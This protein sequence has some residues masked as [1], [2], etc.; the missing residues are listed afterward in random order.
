MQKWLPA[1]LDY[2]PR[3]IEFQMRQTETPGCVVAIAAKGDMVLEQAFGVADLGSGTALTALHRFRVASHSKSFT[4]A[5]IM[6]LREAGRLE[7]DDPAGRFVDGL[8]PTVAEVTLA[9]L[10]S[11]SAGL[12]RDGT[13][14]GQWQDR[15]PFLSEDELRAALAEAPTLPP[16]SRF[17]YSNH[18][19]GL[20]GLIIEAIT[21][22]SYCDWIRREVVAAAGLKETEPDMPIAADAPMARGHGAKLPLGRRLVIPGDNPTHALAAATGFVSTAADLAR[23]FSQLDPEAKQSMLSVASRREMIRRQWRDAYSSVERHYGLGIMCS[24]TGDLEWFGHGG[25]FQGFISRTVVVP[26]HGLA[27]SIVT[28]TVERLAEQWSDGALH[29]ISAFARRGAPEKRLRNWSGRWW[30]VWNALDLVPV[31]DRV[32]ILT[33]ALPNPLTDASEVEVTGADAGQ[34]ALAPGL[35]N[36]GEPVRRSRGA[37][38]AVDEVWLGGTRLLPET[39]MAAELKARYGK[40]ATA[41]PRR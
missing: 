10:L 25:A 30:N 27:V 22:E 31:G 38:G 37:D 34:I 26:Q 32:L 40:P 33:P 23:F 4:A 19:F 21:G 2:I 9:Q 11:H 17:K 16:N 6:K 29:I 12:I 15:R 35:G 7:L 8:H 3:W 36:H 28:N 14:A 13:D 18:G 39:Q 5:A 24:K 20:A 1:A 41:R